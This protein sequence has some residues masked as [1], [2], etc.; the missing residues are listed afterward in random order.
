MLISLDYVAED[1]SFYA[2]LHVQ[3]HQQSQISHIE[4]ATSNNTLITE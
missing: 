1:K 2:S 4:I 3:P